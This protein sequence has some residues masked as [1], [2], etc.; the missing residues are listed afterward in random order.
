MAE[1]DLKEKIKHVAVD[2][3]NK[4][5]YHGATIRHIAADVG[6]SLPMVYYYYQSKKELFHEII[7]RDYFELLDR[8]AHALKADDI[9]DFY[10]SF[11][12]NLNSLSD[13]DRKV[14]RLGVKV[15]LSFDGDDELRDIMDQWEASIL[16][17][18]C[19]LVL[20]HLKN[21]ENGLVIVRTLVHLLENLIESIVVKNR[22]LSEQEIREQIAVILSN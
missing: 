1:T 16:P 12:Y 21:H 5:G 13:Y 22:A 8:Q 10:T 2:H 20:P 19:A 6:C 14:Y 7:K 9:I 18:H 15:Y 4:D 3:F 11:V 17:R